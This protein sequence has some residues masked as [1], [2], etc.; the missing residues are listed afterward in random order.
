ME[1]MTLVEIGQIKYLRKE[2]INPEITV[3]LVEYVIDSNSE[4]HVKTHFDSH[5]QIMKCGSDEVEAHRQFDL[6]V[7]SLRKQTDHIDYESE[8]PQFI[9]ATQ[10]IQS[11]PGL[12]DPQRF[13]NW[14]KDHEFDYIVGY[15]S[16]PDRDPIAT[17][18]NGSL[19]NT[20]KAT[21]GQSEY[22]ISTYFQEINLIVEK[23]Y[24]LPEWTKQFVIQVDR[25]QTEDVSG[26][27]AEQA[28]KIMSDIENRV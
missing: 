14:L 1:D 19:T 25:L 2:E 28:L 8:E 22:S 20:Q 10:I 15:R 4:Y 18:L 7:D 26:I 17:F 13:I 23:M 5:S 3:E 9:F 12:E 27:T 24:M 6:E 11:S 16:Q 21:I